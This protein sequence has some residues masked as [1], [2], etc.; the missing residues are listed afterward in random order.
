MT[1]FYDC[2]KYPKIYDGTYWG[3]FKAS[4]SYHLIDPQIIEN[5]NNF[6]NDYHIKRSCSKDL[7][8]FDKYLQF[9]DEPHLFEHV[10]GYYTTDKKHILVC[11]PYG[12]RPTL[13]TKGWKQIP[14]MYST[15]VTTFMKQ[16]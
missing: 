8:K 15:S 7:K 3:H 14:P 9:K 10:E 6:I 13:L 5:R 4:E 11:S 16:I 12:E 2:T 1:Y